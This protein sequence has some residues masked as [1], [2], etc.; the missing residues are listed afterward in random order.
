MFVQRLCSLHHIRRAI[1]R[2]GLGTH[3]N[4]FRCAFIDL[5]TPNLIFTRM[6]CDFNVHPSNFVWR[7]LLY[8]GNTINILH[9]FI[10]KG[11]EN[12]HTLLTMAENLVFIH[13]IHTL[14]LW[15]GTHTA[16]SSPDGFVP[17]IINILYILLLLSVCLHKNL[18][19]RSHTY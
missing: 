9:C 14:A 15:S 6:A 13:S 1:A 19:L 5:C 18:I 10:V 7:R 8:Y 2:A 17:A 12:L 4:S 16:A 3:S 11:L